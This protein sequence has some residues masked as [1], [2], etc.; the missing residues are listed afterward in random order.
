MKKAFI[1]LPLVVVLIMSCKKSDT[2]ETPVV[3]VEPQIA[4]NLDAVNNSIALSS[5]FAVT[6]TLTSTLPSS[7]GVKIEV[8]V[9]DETSSS[10]ITQSA[11]VTS[12]TSANALQLISLPQQHLCNATVKVSSVKTPSN[13]ASKSF[14]VVY[15]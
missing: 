7:Q 1:F 9:L 4:F 8:T 11:A 15:K 3:V 12:T 6:A 2:A 14:T 10:P 5:S 13:T